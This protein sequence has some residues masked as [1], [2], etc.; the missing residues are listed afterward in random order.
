MLQFKCCLKEGV[1]RRFKL[2]S[3]VFTMALAMP[4]AGLANHYVNDFWGAAQHKH[5]KNNV[6]KH[7]QKSTVPAP[8]K[9]GPPGDIT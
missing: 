7:T 9:F 2:G 3:I 6:T 1:M 5:L 4:I 8:L